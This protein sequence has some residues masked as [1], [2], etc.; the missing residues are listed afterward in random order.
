LTEVR[1]IRILLQQLRPAKPAAS[2]SRR[3][4]TEGST[5]RCTSTKADRKGKGATA[6]TS[7][8]KAATTE[9]DKAATAIEMAAMEAAEG[10]TTD[11]QAAEEAAETTEDAMMMMMSSM[12]TLSTRSSV[13]MMIMMIAMLRKL[14]KRKRKDLKEPSKL[15]VDTCN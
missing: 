14:L 7:S 11:M 9:I 2:T 3:G 15:R 5:L 10:E 12:M 13:T 1:R 8:E 6:T 4:R